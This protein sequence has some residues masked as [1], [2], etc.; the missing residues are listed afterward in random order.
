MKK[1]IGALL[2]LGSLY[3]DTIFKDALKNF[4]RNEKNVTL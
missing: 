3:A 4:R 2:L 1:Y